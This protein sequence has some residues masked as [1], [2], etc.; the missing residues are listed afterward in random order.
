MSKFVELTGNDPTAIYA[1]IKQDARRNA[2]EKHDVI[3]I[4][5]PH[6]QMVQIYDFYH[7]QEPM[8]HN[9][10]A[11]KN[12]F[13]LG[14][15]TEVIAKYGEIELPEPERGQVNE[16]LNTL[17]PEIR[18]W[19]DMF[20][21]VGIYDPNAYRDRQI[22][23]IMQEENT[24]TSNAYEL[25]ND[26]VEN[27]QIA[28]EKLKPMLEE[29][30]ADDL[31]RRVLDRVETGGDP[32]VSVERQIGADKQEVLIH[33]EPRVSAISAPN[34]T[35]VIRE[36]DSVPGATALDTIE[37]QEVTTTRINVR[38]SLLQTISS[39]SDF[40]VASLKEGRFYLERDKLTG[41]ERVVYAR[42][43][44]NTDIFAK[45][46]QLGSHAVASTET[47][48][49]L[50]VDPDVFVFVWP[51]GRPL[52]RGKINTRMEEIMRL[53]DLYSDAEENLS[54]ADR[55]AAY[56]TSVFQYNQARSTGDVTRLTDQQVHFGRGM[57]EDANLAQRLIQQGREMAMFDAHADL[58]NQKRTDELNQRLASGIERPTIKGADGRRAFRVPVEE[59]Y[60]K[61][62]EGF[63]FAG[64]L[65]ST[66]LANPIARRH[67]YR[68]ALASALQVPLSV[69]EGGA[70]FS[71]G[72]GGRMSGSSGAAVSTGSAALS[73]SAMVN[74]VM[75]DRARLKMCVDSLWDIMFRE[76]D[77]D[78][79][80]D[81]LAQARER[82]R[83][84]QNQGETSIEE[85]KRKLESTAE[86]SERASLSKQIEANNSYLTAVA[87]RFDRVA[88]QVREIASMNSRFS[89]HF[90]KMT[91][92]GTEDLRLL[93]ET[94]A[95]SNFEYVNALRQKYGMRALQS[96]SELEKNIK[97]SMKQELTRQEEMMK[98]QAKY[99]TKP[100]FGEEKK[101]PAPG[102]QGPGAKRRKTDRPQK[103]VEE[104]Q[105]KATNAVK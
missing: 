16:A 87:S 54:H 98:L 65:P 56:P 57:S 81:M 82:R 35:A 66:T 28:I 61:L 63:T 58:M 84:D 71:G 30:E 88:S 17:L 19:D 96:E 52:Q 68:T 40:R 14:D 44:Q 95:I 42:N 36:R 92:V 53:R 83:K 1:S 43:D 77:N 75:T 72:S 97:D 105:R 3:Y 10:N 76:T 2:A 94:N 69:L 5:L 55:N 104:D 11:L 37:N 50:S 64:V 33:T 27:V 24:D 49:A 8:I 62:P 93:K 39:I 99:Q 89:I 48:T 32:R 18:A 46:D 47:L 45:Y 100:G 103:K 31:E 38:R 12:F 7:T 22:A 101:R 41:E 20:G 91:H 21:F 85:L 79:L 26:L 60:I 78:M 74:A 25:R 102:E 23:E 13:S 51:G 80:S 9:I 59:K 34:A 6:L 67:N 73:T 70:T 29:G 4:P 86:A 90:V 15:E